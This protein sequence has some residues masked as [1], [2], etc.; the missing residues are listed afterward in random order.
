MLLCILLVTGNSPFLL[1][2]CC[3]DGVEDLVIGMPHRGR[4]NLMT[5]LLH[6]SPQAMFYKVSVII[7]YQFAG[8]LP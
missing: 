6:Y 2:S 4:L 3:L 7:L 8:R 1:V 5:G